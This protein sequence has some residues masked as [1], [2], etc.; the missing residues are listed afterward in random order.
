[1][2]GKSPEVIGEGEKGGAAVL[3]IKNNRGV[4]ATFRYENKPD[5]L[6]E[7]AKIFG[8]GPKRGGGKSAWGVGVRK[9]TG[10]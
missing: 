9:Q 8:R 7:L 3:L 1:M 2:M 4:L 5:S 10:I 6:Q